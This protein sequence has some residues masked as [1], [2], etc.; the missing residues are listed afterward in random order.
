MHTVQN[1]TD[2][3]RRPRTHHGL[4]VPK[5]PIVSQHLHVQNPHQKLPRLLLVGR[6]RIPTRH[7]APAGSTRN[8]RR[9]G[10]GLVI[11]EFLLEDGDFVENDAVF[12]LFGFGFAD[13]LDEFEEL[14]REVHARHDEVVVS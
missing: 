14:A 8:R 7:H 1:T 12:L 13:G 3:T 9:N 4:N 10:T 6:Q 2:N 11:L 5:A